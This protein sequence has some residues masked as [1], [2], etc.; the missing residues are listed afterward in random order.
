M[1]KNLKYP[2]WLVPLCHACN[3]QM[4][5][6]NKLIKIVLL[7]EPVDTPWL[8]YSRK[9]LAQFYKEI[10]RHDLLSIPPLYSK[11]TKITQKEA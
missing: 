8:F 1:L 11:T 6:I 5:Q 4:G 9:K 3:V 10:G 7:H 2:K